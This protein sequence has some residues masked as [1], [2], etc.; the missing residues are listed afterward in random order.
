MT[1]SWQIRFNGG[2]WHNWIVPVLQ[3]PPPPVLLIAAAWGAHDHH[4][5]DSSQPVATYTLTRTRTP[6]GTEFFQYCSPSEPRR[7]TPL[8]LNR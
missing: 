7:P 8:P 5:F 6:R 1:D 4:T 2:P 3:H